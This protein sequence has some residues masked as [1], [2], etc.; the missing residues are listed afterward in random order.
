VTAKQADRD[1]R[2]VYGVG[3]QLLDCWFESRSRYGS[4]SLVFVLF[5]AGNGLCD[6]LITL[7]EEFKRVCV[8]VCVCV[9]VCLIVCDL[10][11]STMGKPCLYSTS[12]KTKNIKH[13][14]CLA[15]VHFSGYD[16]L[17]HVNSEA[18]PVIFQQFK[19]TAHY[20]EQ[21]RSEIN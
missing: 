21:K 19:V 5:C 2:A 1:G 14:N 15:Q 9:F 18:R 17:N 7:S 12:S 16:I 20:T 11:T 8:C 13:G 10:E 4:L 3:I 6:E